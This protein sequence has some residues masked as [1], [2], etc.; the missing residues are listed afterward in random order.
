M[1]SEEERW[2][3]ILAEAAAPITEWSEFWHWLS[4]GGMIG[5]AVVVTVLIC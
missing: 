4:V 2:L 5:F 1:I 3:Y